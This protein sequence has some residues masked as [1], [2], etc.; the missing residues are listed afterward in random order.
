MAAPLYKREDI[1]YRLSGAEIG[2]LEAF[3]IAG[4][5]QVSAG[6][7]E[8]EVIIHQR[9]PNQPTTGDRTQPKLVEPRLYFAEAEL[10]GLCEAL[11]IM[12][13]RLSTQIASVDDLLNGECASVTDEGAVE[14]GAPKFN[15]GDRVWISASARI[16]FF[17]DDIV[18]GVKE[19]GI[20]PGSK[21]SRFVYKLRRTTGRGRRDLVFR[22]DELINKCEAASFVRTALSRQFADAQALHQAH[23]V[24]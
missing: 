16:G 9:P 5:R 14:L 13:A 24:S 15:I 1:V 20:Q 23:C 2:R 6:V 12:V 3:K 11:Q 21:R 18:I 8:Y 19:V 17:E 7:W 22:E 4:S 10:I